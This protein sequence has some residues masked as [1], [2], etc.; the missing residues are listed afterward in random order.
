MDIHKVR[1]QFP[2]LL[3]RQDG[4]PVIH[5]DGPGGTQVPQTVIDA[6]SRPLAEGQSNLGGPFSSSAESDQV[7]ADARSAVAD[8][9]NANSDEVAFGQN[10]TS[11]T[12]AV[13]RAIASTWQPG[14]EIVLTRLDHDANVAPWL[15]AAEERD[16]TV[17]WVGVRDFGIN[18]DDLDA[19]LGSSTRLVAV[20]AASN[21][22]GS[23]VDV[24][25]VARRA[26]DVGALVYVDG[27]H[28]VPH[29]S[30]DVAAFDADFF[31]C[32]AYKFYG[33]HIGLLYGK[34][35]HLRTLPAYKVRPAPDTG[36]GR[37][38]TGTQSFESIAGVVATVDYLAAFGEG[39]DRRQK[40]VSAYEE[41]G[42]HER[43]LSDRFLS[44]LAELDGVKLHGRREGRRTPTFALEFPGQ[45]P[46]DVA[47][48]LA[49]QGIYVTDGDYYAVEVMRSLGQADSGGLVRIGFVHYSTEEEV[50]QTLN[51]LDRLS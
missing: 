14:D 5:L 31:V 40:L 9:L 29:E 7:V 6:M 17:K 21:A 2:A 8:L 43:R 18:W 44:G 20:T 41:I 34:R 23:V 39:D 35:E 1:A 51:A 37:W 38:E 33:P 25:E 22:L 27:V 19:A 49:R 47:V 45:K 28:Y 50:D 4:K 48:E 26:H 16:V 24:A 13:S 10:M 42:Q 15:R 36:P 3:R 30:T 46:R 12:F 32:S 11:L